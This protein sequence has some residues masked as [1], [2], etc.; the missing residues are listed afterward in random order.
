MLLR[1]DIAERI[2]AELAHATRR[3]P[4]ALP[5]TLASRLSIRGELLP[6]V[7]RALGV[8]VLP[9]VAQQPDVYG[10]PSPP[11]LIA[12]AARAPKPPVAPAPIPVRPDN[13]FAALATLRLKP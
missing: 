1:L 13:P 8:R 11:M 9:A 4:T 5:T 7:L 2:A 12:T 6:A 3:R 10:P